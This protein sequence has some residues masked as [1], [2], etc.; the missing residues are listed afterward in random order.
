MFCS[1]TESTGI[2]TVIFRGNLGFIPLINFVVLWIYNIFLVQ[3]VSQIF[4]GS[5]E[6]SN[7]AI[8]QLAC[9]S[10]LL[11]VADMTRVFLGFE[12][13]RII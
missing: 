1:T 10:F 11:T 2:L 9:T 12:R 8:Q 3:L 13:T 6:I 5:F 4:R 7:L